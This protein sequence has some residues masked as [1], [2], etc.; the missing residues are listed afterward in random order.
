ML[1]LQCSESATEN[2]SYDVFLSFSGEDT[3]K[4]FTDHLYKELKDEGLITFRDDEEIQRGESIKS[5]LENGIQQS[6]SW[7]VVFSK[8]YAFSSWCLDE[9]VLI[10]ECR[11]NSKRFLLPIFYHV[12]PSDVRKQSGC[13]SE[14]IDH[15]EEK[16][17]REVDETKRK[18]LMDKIKRWRTALTQ[19]ADLAG[20]PL[21]NVANGYESKLIKKIVKVVQDKVTCKKTLSMTQ[22]PV[23][24][25]PL[26]RHISSWLRNG[27]TDVEVFALY[28][29][30]GVG[31]TTI[32]KCVYNMNLGLFEGHSFLENIREYSERSDGLV[33]LQRQLLSDISKGK[34]PKI[35]N[36]NDGILKIKR[37]LHNRKLL[38][39]LDDVDHVEQL[40]AISGMRE[41]FYQGSKIIITTR[42]VHLLNAYEHCKRYAVETLNSN[43]SLQLFSWHAFQE[44]HPPECYIEHSERVIKQCQGLPLALK[45]LGAS[46]RGKKVDVWRSAME[47]LNIIPHCEIQKILRISYDSL[48]D[49][50]DR[51]LFLDIACFFTGEPKCFVVRILDGCDYYTLIGIE[52]LIDR[53][54]L[55]TDEYENLMMHQSIQSMG[56]EIIRQQSPKDPGQRSR[57]WHCKDSLKVLKDEAGTGAIEGLALEMKTTK[58]YQAELG[59]KA[60]SMM[61]KLRLL[62]LNNVQLSGGL[63]AID[64]QSSKLQT[65]N[66]GNVLLGSLKFLN[67][68]HCNGLVKTPDFAR[69]CALEQLLLE[70]CAS[71]IEIDESIGMAE[72]LVLI[73]LKDCKLLKKLP[74]NL[75]MLKLLE[76]L[77]ISGCSNVGMFPADMRKMESLKNFHA[78]GLNFGNSSD[79]LESYTN[80][81]NSWREFIWGLVSRPSASPKLSLTSLPFNSITRLSLVDCNLQDSSFPKDFGVSTSLEYLNLSQNPIRFLPDCF[82]GLEVIKSLKLWKCNQLQTL[83]GLP[84]IKLLKVRWC[85]LLEKITWKPGQCINTFYAPLNCEK[86]LEMDYYFKIV[87][88]DEIDPELISNCGICDVESMK[89]IHIRLYN[90]LTAAETRLSIQGVH[91]F[92][93]WCKSLNIFYPGSSVPT[94]F[95]SQSYG[96]SL[97]FMISH[98]KL[99]YLNTCIVYKMSPGRRMRTFCLVFHNMTKDKVIVYHPI[100]WG[101]PEGDGY[102]TWICHWKLGTHEV[103]PGDDV[104]ISIVKYDDDSSFKLKEIGVYL[105]YEEQEQEGFRLAK[106]QKVQQ[107]CE[108]I[109]Q[110]V[111]PSERKPSAYHGTT[112][113]YIAGIESAI[114]DRWLERYFGNYMAVE[115]GKPSSP[116]SELN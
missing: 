17:K 70:D 63:V 87:P 35:K 68:S 13:I 5:E 22:H 8:N 6:R 85:Q 7:I 38:I 20:M 109:S 74:E 71:L 39:V 91:E 83:E 30:G 28:G 46:L 82:K 57:L 44:S 75:C 52:N 79:G 18:N 96:P 19:L 84:K 107:T 14:A 50:H 37:S 49:D 53:C 4:T 102:M 77:I 1:K 45:V 56:R 103:G 98:S 21:Q 111:I 101:I 97:S 93:F 51:D 24:I 112:Q 42:N 3:R 47:K 55:K 33:C 62:K 86:L 15:H 106:R 25:G 81:N 116:H 64:M 26:V 114:K 95:T 59:T 115:N 78:D 104:K 67:L 89:V 72:G 61:H 65:F 31:K 27:S 10:L 12:D 92:P 23:G 94:W 48:Q 108:Q 113:V 73:N 54:L 76:T 36:L 58:A 80:Q 16:F 43:D 105:V 2:Y 60:F 88:I 90:E 99:R 9:L 100:C 110:Y 66:Q 34:T 11:N 29:I 32:A 41:W 40:N 69:L